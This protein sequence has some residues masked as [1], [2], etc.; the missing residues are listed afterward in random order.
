M[1]HPLKMY[2]SE[3]FCNHFHNSLRMFSSRSP[4]QLSPSGSQA[5]SRSRQLPACFLHRRLP[6]LDT[7][8]HWSPVMHR[9][10]FIDQNAVKGHPS[11]GIFLSLWELVFS[12]RNSASFKYF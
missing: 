1:I 2:V 11:G 8:C 7:S 5:P 4:C 6:A 3:E 10:L 9:L 12:P